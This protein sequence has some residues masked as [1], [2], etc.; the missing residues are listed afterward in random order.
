MTVDEAQVLIDKLSL[1]K[2][3]GSL[4]E[5]HE[6]KQEAL[7]LSKALVLS[8]Q[9]PESVAIELAF[10]A[11]IPMSARI[12]VDLNLF[13]GRR[14][15]D[16]HVPITSLLVLDVNNHP[17]RILR[18]LADASFVKE[19]DEEM[20]EATSIS[21]AMAKPGVAAGHRV[22]FETAVGAA[23]K[24]PKFFKEAGYQCPTDPRN[25][26][27]QYAN[28]TKLPSFEYFSTVPF[29]IKN[30]NTF[31]GN[32]MGARCY[33]VDWFPVAEQILNGASTEKDSVLMVDVGGGR[34]H[35]LQALYE[36]FPN[37]GKL[38]LQDLP[39][40]L[41]DAE[42]LDAT[43]QRCGYDFFTAQPIHGARVYFFHHILHDWSDEKCLE[44]LQR[45]KSAMRPGYSKLLLHEMIVPAKG[46]TGFH[47]IL[48]LTMMAFN[49]GQE[50]TGKEWKSL[51]DRA[52]FQHV[53]VWLPPQGDADGIVEAVV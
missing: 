45:V 9:E 7:R 50:R 52:G 28:Q 8:L 11:V 38:I 41:E 23:S 32:T 14:V 43:I 44:I 21:L 13:K 6:F 3:N 31:M 16:Q 27:M 49:C 51:L 4:N 26:L 25:G 33:W 17:E 19:V 30:F 46:A 39:H 2:T 10:S 53:K 47:A 20:W 5:S 36:K 29:I 12:A 18:P 42:E 48:D 22:L 37:Q 40:V 34:G 24:A 15:I 1:L 35:D